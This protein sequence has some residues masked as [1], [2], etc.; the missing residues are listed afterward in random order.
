MEIKK[1]NTEKAH[2]WWAI[3]IIL[4]TTA[5]T[6]FVAFPYV[7]FVGTWTVGFLGVGAKRTIEKHGNFNREPHS[8]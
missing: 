4:G 5:A 7:E 8:K 3:G 6:I 1:L 2:L